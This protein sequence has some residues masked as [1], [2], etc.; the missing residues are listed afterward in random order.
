[1]IGIASGRGKSVRTDLQ[2][3]VPK[4]FWQR[5]LIGYYNGSDIGSLK[6]ADHPDK[7]GQPH[8]A[9]KSIKDA[10]KDHP[11]FSRLAKYELRPKQLTV[12]PTHPGL[13]WKTKTILHEILIKLD[14]SGVQVLESSHSIDVIAP[15][16]SKLDVVSACK[17]TA[18]RAG[19]PN[20]ALCVGDKG[21]WPGN[22]YALLSTPYSLSVDTV[23]FD[24][25]S[26]WNLSP[27]GYRGVQAAIEYLKGMEASHGVLRFRLGR[28][29]KPS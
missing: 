17:E 9:L 8:A 19:S 25:E 23:S 29:G 21:E 2:R 12:E 4:K 22:D 14:V 27:A 7:S 26:C 10:L 11:Q 28:R 16:I 5:V 1:M 6:D 24:H 13:W 18:E 20:A 3:L 15:G